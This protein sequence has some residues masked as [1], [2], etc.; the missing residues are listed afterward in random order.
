MATGIKGW[1]PNGPYY[2]S[3]QL[4]VSISN[5]DFFNYN[6]GAASAVTT[7]LKP[8]FTPI[9]P[10]GNYYTVTDLGVRVNAG[11]AASTVGA[12]IYSIVYTA[13]QTYTATLVCQLNAA[14][15]S[16][17]GPNLLV[18]ASTSGAAG[19]GAS[20]VNLDFTQNNYIAGVMASTV[21]TLT[22]NAGISPV[23]GL[24]AINYTDTARSSVTDWPATFT[25]ASGVANAGVAKVFPV[26]LI[27]A[28]GLNWM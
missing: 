7:A 9:R 18:G 12:A 20:T 25:Q 24:G 22:L 23:S 21:T 19:S 16:T 10:T 15:A 11:A 17:T 2:N 4:S 27:T 14:I 26:F 13:A 28:D 3:G 8:T 6:S 1:T 5:T